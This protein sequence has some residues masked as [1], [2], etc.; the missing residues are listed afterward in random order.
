MLPRPKGKMLVIFPLAV[1]IFSGSEIE[2]RTRWRMTTVGYEP[3][4]RW[5]MATVGY[6]PRTRWWMATV[7]YEPR[8][9]WWMTTVGYEPRTRWWMTTVGCEPRCRTGFCTVGIRE[10]GATSGAYEHEREREQNGKLDRTH[11]PS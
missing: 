4:T 10:V 8:T 9:R 11:E 1:M 6:E 5:R 7:G 2:P 3:R